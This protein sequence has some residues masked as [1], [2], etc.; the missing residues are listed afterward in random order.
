MTVVIKEAELGLTEDL[1]ALYVDAGWTIYTEQ[2]DMLEKAF[3]HSLK[4]YVAQVGQDVVGLIRVVGD[5]HSVVFVQDLIVRSDYQ[6]QGIG[7][8]LLEQ[9]F[10]T[11]QNVYQLHLMTEDSEKTIQFY[12]SL[13]M[14]RDS[15]IGCAAFSKYH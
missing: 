11:Y 15:E 4:V 10:E 3:A 2:R 8:R 1:F 12:T 9:V 14:V 7:R 5:G 6:R 13:G